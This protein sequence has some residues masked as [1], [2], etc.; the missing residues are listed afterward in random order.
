MTASRRTGLRPLIAALGLVPALAA[1]ASAQ[2]G[3]GAAAG[4]PPVE[5]AAGGVLVGPTS[6]GTASADLLRPDGGTTSLFKT[7]NRLGPGLGL[8]VTLGFGLTP[9]LF[10]EASG[11]WI[12]ADFETRVT[13]DLEGA[14]DATLT[15]PGNRFVVEGAALWRLA[16]VGGG[17]LFAR[18]GAGWM[19]D[20]AGEGSLIKDGTTGSVG[21]AWRRWWH[22]RPGPRTRRIGLRLD[23]RI[24]IRSAGLTLGEQ[25]TRIAPYA[26]GGV[27]FGF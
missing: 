9:R 10:A 25:K 12:K 26:F 16:T 17:D 1:P 18:G 6:F 24:A 3:R 2:A 19:R 27:V 5:I 23:G 20:L 8:E 4:G 13:S 22:E 15:A 21:V 7:D 11:A 14:D